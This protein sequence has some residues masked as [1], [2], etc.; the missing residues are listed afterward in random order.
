MNVWPNVKA[1]RL[2]DV[3][4]GSLIVAEIEGEQP[5]HHYFFKCGSRG[6][7]S[8]V[9]IGPNYPN[10][11]FPFPTLGV[12]ISYERVLDL[13][14][15]H[16]VILPVND[17]NAVALHLPDGCCGIIV[18]N[19]THFLRAITQ[20]DEEGHRYMHVNL[21]TM[22]LNRPNGP[23]AIFTS[24]KVVMPREEGDLLISEYK[25]SEG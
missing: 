23:R 12:R 1:S 2:E 25:F 13:G 21:E 24:W 4:N 3:R 17:L 8:G 14:T 22:E 16:K 18:I 20:P 15:S 9:P 5:S 6:E 10:N 7:H 11:E 19:E